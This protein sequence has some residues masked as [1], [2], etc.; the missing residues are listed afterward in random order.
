MTSLE[1][2]AICQESTHTAVGAMSKDEWMDDPRSVICPQPVAF[3]G[4]FDRINFNNPIEIARLNNQPWEQKMRIA[5][6]YGW[7]ISKGNAAND[8][9]AKKK[10]LDFWRN[11]PDP[12][13]E[14][15][16]WPN[17]DL[18]KTGEAAGL[19][20]KYGNR[21]I[22]NDML[23]QWVENS[24]R[25]KGEWIA[26]VS[27]LVLAI[28]EMKAG[29]PLSD[30]WASKAHMGEIARVQFGYERKGDQLVRTNGDQW[31]FDGRPY[32]FNELTGRLKSQIETRDTE[33]KATAEM[34]IERDEL[35]KLNE[36]HEVSREAIS[37]IARG[38]HY[39]K[40]AENDAANSK[41]EHSV[42]AK[43]DFANKLRESFEKAQA[44]VGDSVRRLGIEKAERLAFLRPGIFVARAGFIEKMDSRIKAMTEALARPAD[45]KAETSRPRQPKIG[46]LDF[47]I[48]LRN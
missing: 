4:R 37:L 31:V 30:Y 25:I 46:Q 22:R 7:R 42:L 3:V 14:I 29:L 41:I 16:A 2:D 44:E 8:L 33:R 6:A 18:V 11:R 48:I 26:M 12:K 9:A 38:E 27:W 13:A 20:M 1:I 34:Q 21:S 32:S 17:R 15:A 40:K 47:S 28:D 19:S 45:Q 39:I 24:E 43:S 23:K 36:G 35:L 10:I 5:E